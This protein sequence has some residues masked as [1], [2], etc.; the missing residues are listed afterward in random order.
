MQTTEC[1]SI[2]ST[3]AREDPQDGSNFPVGDLEVLPPL[4]LCPD[5][6]GK[7]LAVKT[8]RIVQNDDISLV[9]V[10]RLERVRTSAHLDDL[11]M[12]NTTTTKAAGHANEGRRESLVILWQQVKTN[13]SRTTT[14]P[15]C[16]VRT[17]AINHSSAGG[18]SPAARLAWRYPSA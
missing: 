17:K 15:R 2:P 14:S 16:R 11:H 10:V 18:E 12:Q 3:F 8:H 7:Q 13:D 5:P 9:E 6:L 4:A 1:E